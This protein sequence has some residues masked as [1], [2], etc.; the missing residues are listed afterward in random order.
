MHPIWR[1]MMECPRCRAK[2]D[3]LASEC[4]GQAIRVPTLRS[5]AAHDRWRRIVELKLDHGLTN[6]AICERLGVS[7]D[8]I[9]RALEK[10][11]Y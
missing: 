7:V 8:T 3:R 10:V 11:S 4:E 2:L 6:A 9:Y 5:L 1:A